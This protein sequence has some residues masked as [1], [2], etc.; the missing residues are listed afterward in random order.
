MQG[1]RPA[2]SVMRMK[3]FVKSVRVQDRKTPV[4]T[5]NDTAINDDSK[6]ICIR[7]FK[8]KRQ[9]V[10]LNI[11]FDQLLYQNIIFPGSN[12]NRLFFI[13]LSE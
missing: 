4:P 5:F 1:L 9:I 2:Y 11:R 6:Q 13:C 10:D 7:R 3:G 12:G 8:Q